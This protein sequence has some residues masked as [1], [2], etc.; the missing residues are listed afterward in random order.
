M[1]WLLI[2]P[3]CLIALVA[4]VA[5]IGAMLPRHHVA[6][7]QVHFKRPATVVFGIISDFAAAPSW[8]PDVKSVEMLPLRDGKVVFRESGQNGALVMLVEQ[9][10]PPSRLVNRIVDNSAFGGTWTFELTPEAGGCRLAITERGEVYNPL[11]RVLGRF[12]FSPTATMERYLVA[13]GAKIGE[14]VTPQPT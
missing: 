3:G 10:T 13:L 5:L 14:Q 6:S 11:F 9:S 8:R 2:V 4:V 1:K 12:F 7:R